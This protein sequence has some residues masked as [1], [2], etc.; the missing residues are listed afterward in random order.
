VKG[1]SRHGSSSEPSG[2]YV[3]ERRQLQILFSGERSSPW[4]RRR[5]VNTCR[6]RGLVADGR[7]V[8]EDAPGSGD[9]GMLQGARSG[10]GVTRAWYWCLACAGALAVLPSGTPWS[11]AVGQARGPYL[12]PR[13]PGSCTALGSLVCPGT[14]LGLVGGEG[15]CQEIPATKRRTRGRPSC[16]AVVA[17]FSVVFAAAT[18]AARKEFDNFVKTLAGDSTSSP[19]SV[20]EAAA[21]GAVAG[22]VLGLTVCIAWHG[23]SSRGPAQLPRSPRLLF[24]PIVVPGGVGLRIT[25]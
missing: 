7:L 14:S 11:Q 12:Q 8:S 10:R 21:I 17:S 15:S 5:A 16:L 3:C 4:R 6:L 13:W 9:R 19:P 22:A 24:R 25:R 23:A 20:L 18:I 2:R 1:S